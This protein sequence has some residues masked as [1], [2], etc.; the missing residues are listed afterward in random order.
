MSKIESDGVLTK[1]QRIEYIDTALTQLLF[2]DCL[3]IKTLDIIE[4]ILSGAIVYE[5]YR[6]PFLTGGKKVQSAWEVVLTKRCPTC[7]GDKVYPCTSSEIN[8]QGYSEC[9]DCKG[10]GEVFVW[11]Q[12]EKTKLPTHKIGY[13]DDKECPTCHG[14]GFTDDMIPPSR[15]ITYVP[16]PTCNDN[17]IIETE[18][19]LLGY[20]PCPDCKTKIIC[21]ASDVYKNCDTCPF[22]NNM[23]CP[24]VYRV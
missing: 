24:R 12:T 5:K 11:V 3:S 14:T 23:D 20:I 7:E 17:G 8:P 1:K 16:C 18:P 9:P 4:D 13:L 2:K 10:T 19:P 6:S 22:L 21:R 15:T